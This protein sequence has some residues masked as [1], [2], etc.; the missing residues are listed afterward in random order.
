M[1]DGATGRVLHAYDLEMR[2]LRP[3]A[4][5]VKDGVLYAGGAGLYLVDPTGTITPW[6][7]S[8]PTTPPFSIDALALVKGGV[9]AA[10]SF[11]NG[12]DIGVFDDLSGAF[13]PL[14]PMT[15]GYIDAL[16]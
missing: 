16:A 14:R 10:G 7:P 5:V 8:Y 11:P 6:V 3:R 4:L 15:D 1:L 12:V 9:Y 2:Y 13:H